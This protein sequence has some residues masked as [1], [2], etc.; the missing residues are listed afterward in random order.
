MEKKSD[1][2]ASRRSPGSYSPAFLLAQV[3]AHAAAKFAERL[4]ELKLSPAHAGILRILSSTPAITQQSLAAM[5]AMVPSRL[6]ALIDELEGRGLVERREHAEDRRRYAL[7]LTQ[8]GRSLL[9]MIG[10]ASRE[11]SQTLLAALSKEEQQQLA[12]LLRRIAD[13][14]KLIRG[15]HPG[16][17]H[18]GREDRPR[19]K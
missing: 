19:S 11:H 18:I 9:A 14:Q 17:R 13:E 8:D 7:H 16:Y 5:L 6:V 3:G 2:D 4:E 10:R 12:T 15:V 1:D